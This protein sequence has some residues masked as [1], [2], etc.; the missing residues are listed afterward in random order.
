[1]HGEAK[2]SAEID[3]EKEIVDISVVQTMGK[4]KFGSI[5]QSGLQDAL[6]KNAGEEKTK[7]TPNGENFIVE[8][9]ESNRF[10]EVDSDGNVKKLDIVKDKSPGDIT[11]DKD[12]NPLDGSLEHPYEIWCIE[13]LVSFS[14]SVDNGNTYNGLYINLMTTLDFESNYSYSDYTT[15]DYD[16]YLGG[17]RTT[18]LKTQLSSNGN[19]FIGIGDA[20]HSKRFKICWNNY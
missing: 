9:I 7:A 12:G 16:V 1:M 2:E 13:D 19:G 6:D 14:Q 20:H 17:D 3:N 5:T 4:D 10:Y 18:E 11:K 15:K 8:F